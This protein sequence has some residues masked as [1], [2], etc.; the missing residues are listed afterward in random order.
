MD[1]NA[2]LAQRYGGLS[3]KAPCLEGFKPRGVLLI[4]G[5]DTDALA[6]LMQSV[7]LHT[8]SSAD[9]SERG[10]SAQTAPQE[11]AAAQC[12]PGKDMSSEAGLS[13][14]SG[15]AGQDLLAD[16]PLPFEDRGSGA[17]ARTPARARR[18]AKR[19]PITDDASNTKSRVSLSVRSDHCMQCML[20]KSL[21]MMVMTT[22]ILVIK[23]TAAMVVM[24]ITS[25]MMIG[26]LQRANYT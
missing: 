4:Q 13:V 25:L 24:M 12:S 9:T 17:V 16:C 14:G 11:G 6:G 5:L 15:M 18:P 8:Q 19:E 2:A 3:D 26:P 1:S 7:S 23:M 21:M 10:A 20:N 22:E